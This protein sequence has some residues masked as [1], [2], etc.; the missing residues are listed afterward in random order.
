LR[1]DHASGLRKRQRKD[2]RAVAKKEVMQRGRKR[3]ATT[4]KMDANEIDFTAL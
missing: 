3:P 2:E 1:E 4:W